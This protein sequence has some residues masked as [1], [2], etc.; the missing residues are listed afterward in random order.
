MGEKQESGFTPEGFAHFPNTYEDR[1]DVDSCAVWP[2]EKLIKK[3]DEYITFGETPNLMPRARQTVDE[4]LRRLGFE[5]DSRV[6][7]IERF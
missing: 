5:M 3:I 2:D 7:G 6:D 1:K 4:I